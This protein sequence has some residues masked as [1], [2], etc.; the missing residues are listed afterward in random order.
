MSVTKHE[1]AIVHEGAQIGN[2]TRI[3]A[4]TNIQEGAVIGE[5]C[6]ICDGSF[7]ENGAV[8]GDDVTIKHNVSV[9]DGVTIE[10]GV[11]IGSNV[12]LIND[13]FPRS[14]KKDW[15]LEKTL[16]KKCASIGSNATILCGLT[17]NEYSVVGAGSVVTSDVLRHAVV[18]GNPAKLRG[19]ACQCGRKLNQY[20]DCSCGRKYTI[21][22]GGL[23][24]DE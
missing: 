11:F 8:I 12:A 4:N 7:V 20:Y 14:R 23:I 19:Y 15:E 16:I 24:F 13:R 17:I 5:N 21:S 18:F 2:G 6:N 22:K 3:W 1:T 10:N 9:F